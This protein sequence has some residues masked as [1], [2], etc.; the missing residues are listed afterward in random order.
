MQATRSKPNKNSD[1]GTDFEEL[2]E[3]WARRITAMKGF[4][5]LE[6]SKQDEWEILDSQSCYCPLQRLRAET[7]TTS[8]A[9]LR[10][11]HRCLAAFL[12]EADT[13]RAFDCP[14]PE[15]IAKGLS[16]SCL[17]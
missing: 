17:Q 8:Q 4:H 2:Q 6:V 13:T 5:P 1:S 14:I 16:R 12:R 3:N 11:H 15:R 7:E 9:L 10:E